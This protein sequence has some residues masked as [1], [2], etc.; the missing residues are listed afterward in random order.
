MLESSS[1]DGARIFS[2]AFHQFLHHLSAGNTER[3]QGYLDRGLPLD[4]PFNGKTLLHDLIVTNEVTLVR[5]VLKIGANPRQLSGDVHHLE[6]PLETAVLQGSVAVLDL[7]LAAVLPDEPEL[8]TLLRLAG[9]VPDEGR[10]SAMLDALALYGTRQAP[11]A[12]A[13]DPQ[14][15]E[16][17]DSAD[18]RKEQ[19]KSGVEAPPLVA[20]TRHKGVPARRPRAPRTLPPATLEVVSGPMGPKQTDA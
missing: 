11:D 15:P 18:R 13:P 1:F 10:R 16:R 19:G 8:D 3:V 4:F 14:E 20:G 7:L 6:S 5:E 17:E 12:P 9:T 2:R